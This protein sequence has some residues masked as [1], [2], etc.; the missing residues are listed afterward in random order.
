MAGIAIALLACGYEGT[1]VSPEQPPLSSMSPL[2]ELPG[3]V[4]FNDQEWDG[5]KKK[6]WNY[7]RRTASKNSDIVTDA[8]A[9]VSSSNALRI[10]FTADMARDSEPGVHWIRLPAVKEVYAG[11]SVKWSPNWTCSPAGCGK[12]AFFHTG[13]EGVVYINYGDFG[14]T[15]NPKTISVNT[16]WAPYGDRV[17]PANRALTS[18]VPGT[19]YRIGWYHKYASSASAADGMIRWW[20]DGVLNGEYT[21]VRFPHGGFVQFEFA[22]TIQNPPLSEQYMYIDHT[23]IGIRR[24]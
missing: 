7:L 14:R 19:W 20:V 22:P 18:I 5:L 9:P 6:G 16:H 12:I 8:T 10:I 4:P 17:W 15:A 24:P 3:L 23:E 21:D 2:G 1:P 11:W 13:A